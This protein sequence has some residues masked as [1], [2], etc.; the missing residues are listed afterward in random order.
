MSTTTA[1][2]TAVTLNSRIRGV[3]DLPGKLVGTWDLAGDGPD[4]MQLLQRYGVAAVGFPWADAADESAMFE[5][6][7][8]GTI[9]ALVLD[10]STLLHRAANTCDIYVVGDGFDPFDQGIVLPEGANATALL[11]EVDRALVSLREGGTTA[12]LVGQYITPPGPRC[13]SDG[14]LWKLDQIT[15]SQVAG[16]WAL[17]GIGAGI[18]VVWVAVK[19]LYYWQRH[20]RRAR[21]N[22]AAAEEQEQGKV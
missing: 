17:L 21:R 14:T 10:A 16:L 7:R 1:N 18:V 12:A 13:K 8:N 20:R 2:I 19:R 22:S 15:M 4:Y 3:Q 11:G 9:D 6:L 5:A